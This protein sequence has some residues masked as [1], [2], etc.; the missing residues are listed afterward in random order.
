[1]ALSRAVAA[2]RLAHPAADRARAPPAARSGFPFCDERAFCC[3]HD[4]GPAV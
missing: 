3:R 2:A 4:A 1:M